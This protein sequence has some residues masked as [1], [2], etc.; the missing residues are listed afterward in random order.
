MSDPQGEVQPITDEQRQAVRKLMFEFLRVHS[1]D[2][3]ET[4]EIFEYNF[5]MPTGNVTIRFE[6]GNG[7]IDWAIRTSDRVIKQTLE[8]ATA[9]LVAEG[10]LEKEDAEDPQVKI[11]FESKNPI[12]IAGWFA[13]MT[14]R[15]LIPKMMSAFTELGMESAKVLEGVVILSME[16]TGFDQKTGF[17]IPSIKD[18]MK[19]LSKD[20]AATRRAFLFKQI[21][22]ISGEPQLDYL[23]KVYQQ[24]LVI[25]QDV[26]KIHAANK[27]TEK[28]RD[29]V[30][31]KYDD[32]PFDDDLL[33][34]IST[35]PEN[36]P[37]DIQEKVAETD[38]D[39]TPS[40]IALEHSARLCGCKPYQ[41]G[42]RHLFTL[43][44][45]G[46]SKTEQKESEPD[47]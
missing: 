28:W 30:K 24:M 17:Q 26:K 41:F 8:A 44:R 2:L 9:T 37:E 1:P 12:Q 25:W 27:E 43:A 33:V 5:I 14:M 36:L 18:S 22:V 39:Q 34:R 11:V 7:F 10:K 16:Q 3:D 40:S 42:T 38:G 4:A 46:K 29:M 15:S 23:P 19:Q 20:L 35:K 47:Q 32:L 13:Y 45:K 21:S 31:A 6:P